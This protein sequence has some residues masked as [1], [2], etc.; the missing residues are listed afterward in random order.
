[1]VSQVGRQQDPP[2]PVEFDL[3]RVGE[4]ESLE[5]AGGF[6]GDGQ[7][8]DL[9]REL[10]PAGLGMDGQACVEPSRDDRARAQLDAEL[11]GDGDP[12][13]VVHRVPVL[14]GEHPYGLLG[15]RGPGPVGRGF[16]CLRVPHFPPL[17]T[18]SLH[19]SALSRHVNA[20][21]RVRECL[22][23][24]GQAAACRQEVGEDRRPARWRVAA[25]SARRWQDRRP[26]TL[27]AD[28]RGHSTSRG[29]NPGLSRLPMSNVPGSSHGIGRSRL[30]VTIRPPGT[31]GGAGGT[32]AS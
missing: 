21:N 23:V 6:A 1:M 7:R 15:L 27:M 30:P 22:G 29:S 11:R 2:L 24:A 20:Q 12:S 5:A 25:R 32:A 17:W 26:Q 31:V 28:R 9:R 18:T 3:R 19:S 14:A 8:R 13:L 4:H 10:V 16:E